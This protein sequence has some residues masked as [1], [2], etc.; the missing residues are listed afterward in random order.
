MLLGVLGIEARMISKCLKDTWH[1]GC[2]LD[3]FFQ[4]S[5]Y[6]KTSMTHDSNMKAEL[7]NFIISVKSWV[8][9]GTNRTKSCVLLIGF[10]GYRLCFLFRF[11]ACSSRLM[12]FGHHTR[13]EKPLCYLQ[14]ESIL[15]KRRCL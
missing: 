6:V 4:I 9:K 7:A 12:Y 11:L 2:R 8:G 1:K 13:I 15:M 5:A 10:K 3:Y 14:A